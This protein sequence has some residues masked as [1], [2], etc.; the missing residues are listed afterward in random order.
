[1]EESALRQKYRTIPAITTEM[2]NLSAILNLPKP[3]E[4]FMSDIHG[5]YD[6]FQHVLRNGSGNISL[7]INERFQDEMTPVTRK[8]FAFL[9]YYPSERLAAI[10]ARLDADDLQ[11]WY[12][13]TFQRLIA[14][15]AYTATK[16]TRSKLRKALAPEY[17]YITE[18]LLYNDATTPDKLAYYGQIIK[19]LI[20]LGQADAWIEATCRSIQRLTVDRYHIV[21]D[22]YDRGPAPDKVM[23]ALIRRQDYVDIQW[24]NHD[25]LWLGGA[26]GSPL[27]IANLIRI[28]ARYNNLSI[29][30][31][32]YGINLRHLASLAEHYYQDNPA[33]QPQITPE[34]VISD[35]ER[36][37]IAKIHQVISIIQFKLEGPA[38]NRRPEFNMAH[39]LMLSRLSADHKTIHLNNQ[40][41]PVTNGNF[42]TVAIDDPYRLLPEEAAVVNQLI[43]AFRHSERLRRHMD[44]LLAHG[45]MYKRNNGNLLLHGCVP[46]DAKGEFAALTI[47]GHRYAGPALFTALEENLRAAYANP[48]GATSLGTD[49]LWYLWTGPYSPLFGKQE[50][51]TF[52]RYYVADPATHVEVQNPYYQLRHDLQFI[53]KVLVAFGLEASGRVI[54][55]HTPVKKGTSPT[56]ADNHMIVIDGGFSKPY[57]KTTGIGG[58][59]LLDNSYGLQLVTHQPFITRAAA[60][61]HLTD[62][63]STRQ[64]VAKV[65]QRRTVAGTDIGRSLRAQL[66]VLNQLLQERQAETEAYPT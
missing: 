4:G 20:D 27:C 51:T 18:E 41:Y 38:I 37:Q 23:E 58:Y 36:L 29:L 34:Q 65:A 17:A 16:Y 28:S 53:E 35:E 33:F 48:Q 10:K 26:A 1:M 60:I 12:L 49:L 14:L 44:F 21:G 66:K 59:T 45:S 31:D 61:A 22:I 62:I 13:S 6:A 2:I 32:A 11:Q 52:E 19:N 9:V 55:G 7:K 8:E 5:E 42:Q 15:L 50:M 3:T 25:I 57:Q 63:V 40:D 43:Q 54:N 30:E 56:M 47:N 46:V 64:V 39:R 24:G